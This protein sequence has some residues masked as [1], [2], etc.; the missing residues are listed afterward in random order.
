[1]TLDAR[2]KETQMFSRVPLFLSAAAAAAASGFS[3]DIACSAGTTPDRKL[4]SVQFRGSHRKSQAL[5]IFNSILRENHGIW[6]YRGQ[7]G[8]A[9]EKL[10]LAQKCGRFLFFI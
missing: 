6:I 7:S 1:M 9:I 4:T 5:K 3:Q 2:S 8:T 10:T